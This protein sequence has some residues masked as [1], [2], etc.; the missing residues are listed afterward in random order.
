[1]SNGVAKVV[2]STDRLPRFWQRD[3]IFFANLL[4]LFFGNDSEAKVLSD[5]IGEVDSYGGRLM[6]ILNLLFRDGE[7]LLYLERTPDA[8]LCD[9]FANRL[10][11]SLPRYEVISHSDYQEIGQTLEAGRHADVDQLLPSTA[12][13]PQEWVDGYVTDDTLQ[14]LAEHLG[15]QTI[16]TTHGSRRGNNKLLLHQFVR[17]Q[18]LPHL[19]TEL[20][21]STADLAG[22]VKR[23]AAKGYAAAVVKSQIGA[24]GIGIM[25]IADI[26]SAP[27]LPDLPT[28]MF[29]EGPCMVQG[30]SQPGARGV[31][32]VRSPSVQMFL[33]DTTVYLYDTTEQI[34]SRDSVHEGNLSPVPYADQCAGLL[35]EMLRQAGVVGQWLHAQGYRGTASTDFLVIDRDGSAQSE[36]HVCEVNARVTGATYPSVLAPHFQPSGAWLMRNLRLAEPMSGG[37]LLDVL[38]GADHLYRP[39]RD[40]GVLPVNFNCGADGLVHK[41]QFLLLAATPKDCE[42]YLSRI[43]DELPIKWTADRD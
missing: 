14:Q 21:A 35:P 28:H 30:W 5:E 42:A 39:Q 31:T 25:K 16:S 4:G 19:D 7:N 41:G 13:G 32:A 22:C 34:L 10:S 3:V 33:D 23:L 15:K 40:T 20:A 27:A 11:L 29:Y 26:Q 2:Q 37:E 1:M 36:V 8:A 12:T 24:S 18:G 6:P 43:N 9:Y 17:D 38:A